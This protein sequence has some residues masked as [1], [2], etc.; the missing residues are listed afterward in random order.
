[1]TILI[2]HYIINTIMI[3]IYKEG[4]SMTNYKKPYHLL[5]NGITDALEALARLDVP[6]AIRLLEEAQIKA[7]EIVIEYD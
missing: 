5:F 2:L 1:M 3:R 6:A 4:I 7:E